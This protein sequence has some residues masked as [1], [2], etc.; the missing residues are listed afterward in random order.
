MKKYLYISFIFLFIPFWAVAQNV[1]GSIVDELNSTKRG[2]GNIKVLQ[3]ETVQKVL[4][5]R[6]A[7]SSGM[8][9]SST[10]VFDPNA[11]YRTVRG[12]KIQAYS[13]NNQARSKSIAHS[14]ESQIKEMFPEHETIV[15]FSSPFWRL[16]I[17]NFLRRD[18]AEVFLQEL[19]KAFPSYGKEMYVL[20]D[21]VKIPIE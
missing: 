14:R 11:R 20:A 10:K 15:E 19:K 1:G 3:D 4:S 9:G 17:G 16:R 5:E 7:N 13:G 8:S 18:D 6:Y 21:V 12:F 2:Q